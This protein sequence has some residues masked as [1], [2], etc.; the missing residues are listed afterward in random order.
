MN[1]IS[2]IYLKT[3]SHSTEK[4]AVGLF[5]I[6]GNDKFFS[7]SKLKIKIANKIIDKNISQFI[8]NSLTNFQ[9]ELDKLDFSKSGFETFNFL[10]TYSKGILEFEKLKPIAINL[11][12]ETFN[13]LY[14][15]IIENPK[16]IVNTDSFQKKVKNKLS[17]EAFNKIDKNYLIPENIINRYTA[18]KV[19]FIGKNGRILS[20]RAINFEDTPV[21]IDKSLMEFH[22]ISEALISYENNLRKKYNIKLDKGIH[23]VYFSNPETVNG[24]IILDKVFK[25][26]N[27]TFEIKELN[28]IDTL[29]DEI[30]AGEYIKFSDFISSL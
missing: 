15:L 1:Y 20:G 10:N 19:D 23:T 22:F 4:I 13:N 14:N 24:K 3:N 29:I 30:N 16:D 7:F 18:H 28:S 26:K 6:S 2:T 21:N 8:E 25:D 17:N 9:L 12:T 5:G 27:K 11:T